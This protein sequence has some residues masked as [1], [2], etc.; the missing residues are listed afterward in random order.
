[1]SLTGHATDN[2]SCSLTYLY[3]YQPNFNVINNI[4]SISAK[5]TCTIDKK[6][7][8][9]EDK[10]NLNINTRSVQEAYI[11]KRYIASSQFTRI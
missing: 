5:S 9:F 8:A 7:F 11:L 6:L 4:Q 1:M 10:H 2:M 3:M